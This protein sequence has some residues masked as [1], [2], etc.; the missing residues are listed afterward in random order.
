MSF[1]VRLAGTFFP[2]VRTFRAIA[3]RPLWVDALITVLI[4]TCLFTYFTF[5]FEQKDSLRIVEENEARLKAKW[6]ESG[7]AS[8]L[9]R[10]MSRNRDL[11]AFLVTPLTALM[12][13]LFSALIVLGIGRLVSTQGNY[14]QVFASLLHASFVDK[15][16]GNGL[17]FILISRRPSIATAST[18]L[19][20]FFPNLGTTSTISSVLAQV[21][22]FQLW[23]FCLFGLGLAATFKIST[24]KGLVISFSLWALRSAL[25]VAL[26]FLRTSALR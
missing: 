11:D 3:E 14:P 7:Y 26:T 8:E 5:P 4:L 13:I 15:I 12:G 19:L 22:I 25:T 18:S 10:I 23:M 17:R 1:L 9:E 16:L 20:V 2:P 6:G 21:D 24:K